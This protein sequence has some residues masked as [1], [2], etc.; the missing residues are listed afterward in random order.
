MFFPGMFVKLGGH[1]K[2]RMTHFWH[3]FEPTP[4]HPPT[5]VTFYFDF[6]QALNFE[7]NN[8]GSECLLK[9]Q[10]FTQI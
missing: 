4:I 8:T 2:L 3:F 5:R 6:V 9:P 10:S 7:E 1:L